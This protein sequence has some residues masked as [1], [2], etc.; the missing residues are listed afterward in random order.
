VGKRIMWFLII[1]CSL[2]FML[3]V[4]ISMSRRL[5]QGHRRVQQLQRRNEKYDS[6]LQSHGPGTRKKFRYSKGWGCY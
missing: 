1:N 6:Q 5:R 3:L 4:W 2:L